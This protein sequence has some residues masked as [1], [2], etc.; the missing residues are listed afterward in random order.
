M[1]IG[2]CLILR[3]GWIRW[4]WIRVQ[5]P[6]AVRHQQ[7]PLT[8]KVR[9]KL[10]KLGLLF[11][12]LRTVKTQSCLQTRQP[13]RRDGKGTGNTYKVYQQE[14][15][16]DLEVRGKTNYERAKQDGAPYVMKN[17]APE[18]L[19]LHHSRQNGKGPLL[20][21]SR[22]THFLTTKDKGQRALHPYGRKK[23]PDAPVDSKLFEKEVP[24]Y[25]R[26]RAAEV[27]K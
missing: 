13:G 23:H 5:E 12:V 11:Q 17:G 19:Q 6:T 18:Q 24:Q 10:M 26:D 21:L 1:V 20:E 16:W 15:D 4:G 25:W 3:A 22:I 2:M 7:N 9:Q 27:K 8:Q 14:I